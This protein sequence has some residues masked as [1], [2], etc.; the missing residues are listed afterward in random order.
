MLETENKE[1]KGNVIIIYLFDCPGLMF[2]CLTG[3]CFQYR[4]SAVR[5]GR[6]LE[7][8]EEDTPARG[9]RAW[10]RRVS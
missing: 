6:M 9:T 2:D 10:L 3:E 8:I 5:R 1:I 4:S 7:S